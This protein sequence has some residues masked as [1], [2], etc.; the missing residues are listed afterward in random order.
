MAYNLACE[1]LCER[2]LAKLAQMA[3]PGWAWRQSEGN[4]SPKEGDK[5]GHQHR[6]NNSIDTYLLD[7]KDKVHA[8][9]S[10]A[11]LCIP[12]QHVRLFYWM[13]TRMIGCTWWLNNGVFILWPNRQQLFGHNLPN[14]IF[15]QIEWT[16]LA[17]HGNT[18]P[19][20]IPWCTCSS[21]TR[22]EMYYEPQS[23]LYG[24]D[25]SFEAP[26][27]KEFGEDCDRS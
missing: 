8:G 14:K 12:G 24:N 16:N 15:L 22:T 17:V 11:S 6:P 19:R 2:E 1:W 21:I 20:S 5:G 25:D 7:S 10:D 23:W 9:L 27:R 13:L 4:K 26:I 18:L 3:T